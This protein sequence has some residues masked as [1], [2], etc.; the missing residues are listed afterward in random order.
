M[1]KKIGYGLVIVF[2][3]FILMTLLSLLFGYQYYTVVSDSMYPSIPK[4]SLVYV[5]K[6]NV[7]DIHDLE[8][9]VIAFESGSLPTM[10]RVIGF[11]EGKIITHGDNNDENV[12][13][14]VAKEDVIG[15]VVLSIPLIGIL[16]NSI[17]PALIFTVCI[18]FYIILKRLIKELKK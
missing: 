5:K 12:N 16:F 15:V 1:I 3:I 2:F 8:G 4:N 14:E 6:T 7:V 10:H 9:K 13:E 11:N 18:I 17:Y